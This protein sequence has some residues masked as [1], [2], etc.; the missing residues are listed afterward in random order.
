[1]DIKVV[2]EN[3]GGDRVSCIFCNKVESFKGLFYKYVC[4]LVGCYD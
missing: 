2:G 1:M 4:F 3:S